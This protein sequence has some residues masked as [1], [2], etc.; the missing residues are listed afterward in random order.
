[1][2]VT[3]VKDFLS[4]EA[5]QECGQTQQADQSEVSPEEQAQQTGHSEASSE[6]QTQQI[7]QSEA[8]PEAQTQ[9]STKPPESSGQAEEAV[10]GDDEGQ[11]QEV[12]KEGIEQCLL[13][14]QIAS[15]VFFCVCFLPV[16]TP[17]SRKAGE[18]VRWLY[19]QSHLVSWSH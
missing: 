13:S 14:A 15:P 5:L 16:A 12:E 18:S 19:L 4:P 7:S 17:S 3:A 8:S 1:M 10:E 11:S 2:S 6:A 9:Q